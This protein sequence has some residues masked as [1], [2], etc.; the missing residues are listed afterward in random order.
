MFWTLATSGFRKPSRCARMTGPASISAGYV[1][2][3]LRGIDWEFIP[4]QRAQNPVWLVLGRFRLLGKVKHHLRPDRLVVLVE[5]QHYARLQAAD[6]V[7]PDH[8]R[9]LPGVEF[10]HAA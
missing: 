4:R 10:H 3:E 8:D 1:E 7:L 9:K 6:Q 2:K 5:H